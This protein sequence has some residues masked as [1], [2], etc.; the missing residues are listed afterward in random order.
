MSLPSTAP[1]E[2]DDKCPIAR[3][4]SGVNISCGLR[5]QSK[6]LGLRREWG[7]PTG[8]EPQNYRAAQTLSCPAVGCK[9]GFCPLELED[10][11]GRRGERP[12]LR[13]QG[14]P[15]QGRSHQEHPQGCH[16][17]T[18]Q[19]VPPFSPAVAGRPR[20][21]WLGPLFWGL[22]LDN[23]KRQAPSSLLQG[24]KAGLSLWSSGRF[25]R[26]LAPSEAA[27]GGARM[28]A[29]WRWGRGPAILRPLT[30]PGLPG[31]LPSCGM[32]SYWETGTT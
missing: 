27:S 11:S 3:E 24:H 15:P 14:F 25:G 22:G 29:C 6:V 16:P 21:G 19:P 12:K 8:L 1:R 18:A 30:G 9:G 20:L 10:P 26:F 32:S 23:G 2:K 13:S 7:K 28:P 31:W 5:P 17:P 4:G